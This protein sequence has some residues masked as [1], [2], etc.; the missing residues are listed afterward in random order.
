MK[1]KAELKKLA[2]HNRKW[3]IIGIASLLVLGSMQIGGTE[4]YFSDVETTSFT[5]QAGD[6]W[7]TIDACVRLI[8]HINSPV[9]ALIWLPHG[10][11]V[12]DIVVDSVKLRHGDDYVRA[13]WGCVFCRT[14][15]VTF[16]RDEVIEMLDGISHEGVTLNVTGY[17][18]SGE[19]FI[20]SDKVYVTGGK[21]G[22][23][24]G[25]VNATAEFD[26][27][28]SGLDRTESV[29]C[30]IQLP[31][32]YDA[33]EI[34]AS[35]LLLANRTIVLTKPLSSE[36][37]DHDGDGIL[38]LMVELERGDLEEILN[39]QSNN[40]MAEISG[41]LGSSDTFGGIVTTM[42]ITGDQD[43]DEDTPDKEVFPDEE[44]PPDEEATPDEEVPDEESTPNEDTP[45]EE[46]TPNE[47]VTPDE[48]APDEDTPDEKPAPDNDTSPD[49]EATPQ[50]VLTPEPMP[51]FAPAPT[52][53]LTPAS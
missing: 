18:K 22:I 24:F 32:G 21:D 13:R 43:A 8:P 25:T 14:F 46:A 9:V 1:Y 28:V 17:L 11:D 31:E 10:Y 47:E 29:R 41:I 51:T 7:G 34:D 3:L 36:I 2:R 16:G 48:N 5:I 27:S 19:Y 49:E 15:M 52:D 35:T 45:D 38:D 40:V 42:V 26:L 12:N 4:A 33:S 37:G 6:D 53:E 50:P 30:Y 39:G 44:S 23:C 20:G